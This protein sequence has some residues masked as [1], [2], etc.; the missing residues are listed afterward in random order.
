MIEII[1]R[2]PKDENDFVNAL[3]K[4]KRKCNKDGF[5]KEIRDRRYFKSSSEIKREKIKAVERDRA[6]K[7]K[8]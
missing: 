2:N 7:K 6:L 8:R 5:L 3:A 4:F 1:V